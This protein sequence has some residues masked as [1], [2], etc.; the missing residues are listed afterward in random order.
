MLLGARLD[1]D[2]GRLTVTTSNLD[3]TITATVDA[4]NCEPGTVIPPAALLH[5]VV[6]SFGTE[7][8]HLSA[9]DD[10]LTMSAGDGDAVLRLL[11]ATEWPDLLHE[12]SPTVIN[13]NPELLDALERTAY[14]CAPN[15]DVHRPILQTVM[16]ANG[17]AVGTDSYR[18]AITILD[19]DLPDMNI[20]STALRSM[21]NTDIDCAELR[22]NQNR[23]TIG[24]RDHSWTVALTTGAAPD[25]RKFLEGSPLE[26]VTVNRAE[27]LDAVSAMFVLSAPSAIAATIVSAAGGILTVQRQ[28]PASGT[29]TRHVDCEGECTPL[30][31]RAAFLR[32]TLKQVRADD[33]TIG[34]SGPTKPLTIVDHGVTHIIMPFS[35]KT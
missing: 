29:V 34:I 15:A 8:L 13:L 35:G 30:P 7:P 26:Q 22:Y 1:V 4:V 14:A 28:D 6:R 17:L 25:M 21:L 5:K 24:D 9:D 18:A 16:V 3:V 10:M 2:G 23:V 19:V 32:D 31:I 20:H 12:D 11:P 33:V 27:L